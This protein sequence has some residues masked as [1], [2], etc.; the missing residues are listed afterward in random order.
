MHR[1]LQLIS[2]AIMA[3]PT[4]S[5]KCYATAEN[6]YL[7]T[8]DPSKARAYR[9]PEPIYAGVEQTVDGTKE[10]KNAVNEVLNRMNQYFENEVMTKPEYTGIRGECLNKNKLCAFWTSVGE[11]NG[12]RGFMLD[13]CAAS[14]MLCQLLHS[15]I[16][17]Q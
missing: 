8:D 16:A 11:C 6:K 1:F 4:L 14:C 17:K 5:K 12:N 10:E 3:A 9:D 13:N 2:I 15:G 7:C